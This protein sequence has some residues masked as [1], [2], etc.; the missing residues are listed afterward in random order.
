[1]KRKLPLVA[2]LLIL[3]AA[4][5]APQKSPERGLTG[6]WTNSL[7]TVWSVNSNGKFDVDLNKDGKADAVGHYEI[8]GD[9]VR[10]FDTT[11]KQPNACKGEAI[12]HFH[13]TGNTL[14]FTLVKDSCKKRI[15][16][17]LADWHRA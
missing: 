8:A 13:V 1:M 9:T 5:A 4:C 7:G 16:N 15:K 10:I 17:V 3:L 6:R 14:H 11:D 2:G 12:Y